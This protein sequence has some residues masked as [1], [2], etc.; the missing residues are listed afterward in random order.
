MNW[1]T[2]KKVASKLSK[3]GFPYQG[4]TADLDGLKVWF[5]EFDGVELK[6]GDRAQ[7]SFKGQD[8]KPGIT[9]LRSAKVLDVRSPGAAGTICPVT[10]LD[11]DDP[12]HPENAEAVLAMQECGQ[13]AE[14][15]EWYAAYPEQGK[16]TE[17]AGQ[18]LAEVLKPENFGF[19]TE[20]QAKDLVAGG[21]GGV[22]VVVRTGAGRFTTPLSDLQEQIAERVIDRDDYVR[23][24]SILPD[25]LKQLR[26]A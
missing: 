13:E 4:V 9:F 8:R 24:V 11:F 1:V 10:G 3:R 15:D 17:K 2:V 22:R 23:D 16:K 7:V 6:P 26:A 25:E 5:G 14:L 20:G 12:R 18:V 21:L 19:L